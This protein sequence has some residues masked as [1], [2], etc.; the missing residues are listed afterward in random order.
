VI[1]ATGCAG[2]CGDAAIKHAPAPATTDARPPGHHE[3]HELPLE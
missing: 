1:A 3:D 2:H